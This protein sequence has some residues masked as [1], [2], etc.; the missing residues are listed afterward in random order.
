MRR[1]QLNRPKGLQQGF[2]L[3][4]VMIMMMVIA[5]LVVAAAQSYNTELRISSN[6][7]DR[8]L[9]MSVAEAALRQGESRIAEMN[10]PNFTADCSGGLCAPAYADP[11]DYKDT[12]QGTIKVAQGGKTPVW[13]PGSCDKDK[14]SCLDDNGVTFAAAGSGISRP[15]RYVIEFINRQ[16]NAGNIANIY[17][18]TARAWGR[19]SNTVVTVQS[20]VEAAD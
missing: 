8:K 1:P 5:V 20:Y 14:G 2:A 19:N 18:V 4:I 12:L 13:L 9:A 7:A 6:D 10:D 15:A 16:N 17:R 3:F 11:I